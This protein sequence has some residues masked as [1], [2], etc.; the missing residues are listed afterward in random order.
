MAQSLTTAEQETLLHTALERFTVIAEA[1]TEIRAEALQDMEFVYNIGDGQWPAEIRRDRVNR[2]MLTSNKLRKFAAIVANQ[3]VSTRPA[4]GVTPVDDHSDPLVARVLEDLIR[5]IEYQSTAEAVYAR[6]TEHAVAMGFGFW[7]LLTRY[8][9]GTFEQ[10]AYLAAVTNPFSIY[11]DHERQYGFVRKTMTKAEFQQKYPTARLVDFSDQGLGDT[12]LQWMDKDRPVVAEYFWKEPVTTTL[13][14]VRNLLTGEMR[15]LTLSDGMTR[16]RLEAQGMEVLRTREECTHTVKWATLTGAEVLDT[17]DWPGQDIPIIEVS[18]DQQEVNGR[19]YKRSVT[20]DAKDPQ[21]MANYW[22]TAVTETLALAPKAPYFVTPEEI[23]GHEP[24]WNAANLENRPY[25]LYNAI[26]GRVPSRQPPPQ[27]PTGAMTMLQLA[28]QDIKDVIG[29]FEAGLGE[30]SNERSGVA[31]RARQSRSDRG[32]EHFYNA[33]R[34]AIIQTGRQLIDLIPRLYDTARI[35]RIRGVD[36]QEQFVPINMPM[37]DP[38]TGDTTL[39]HDLSAGKF[40]IEASM[41]TYQTRREE[42]TEGMIQAMQYAPAMSPIIIPYVFKYSDW[43]G[44]EEIAADLTAAKEQMMAQGGQM[45][46][47]SSNGA[48]LSSAGRPPGSRQGDVNA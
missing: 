39:L 23:Q 7:R 44:A 21:R 40:D 13:A 3:I 9:P 14:Q 32:T 42:A 35:A 2:P 25:L 24:M 15:V 34:L 48:P 12:I 18:G 11:L 4:I 10:E 22:R 28:D 37:F 20:R 17:R 1:E 36:G 26:G 16:G 41:R 38:T 29:I 8:I 5:N 19:I 43:P 33:V 6:A 27:I 31:I 46:P 45:N 30:V 47:A